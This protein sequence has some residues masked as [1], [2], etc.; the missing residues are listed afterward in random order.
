MPPSLLESQFAALERLEDDEWGGE[1][2]I[3]RPFQDVVEQ[4]ESYVKRTLVWAT[5]LH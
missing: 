4:S 2:N 3:A 5:A 1:I